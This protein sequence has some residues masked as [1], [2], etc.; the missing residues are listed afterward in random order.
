M[1][2]SLDSFQKARP[3]WGSISEYVTTRRYR[4]LFTVIVLIFALKSALLIMLHSP[5]VIAC[6]NSAVK[7][8]PK[9]SS[10]EPSRVSTNDARTSDGVSAQVVVNGNYNIEQQHNDIGHLKDAPAVDRDLIGITV[11]I[12]Y[13]LNVPSNWYDSFETTSP[14]YDETMISLHG[15]NIW[16]DEEGDEL[17]ELSLSSLLDQLQLTN[18]SF[19]LIGSPLDFPTLKK[20]LEEIKPKIFL[21]V[22]VFQGMTSTWVAHYFQSQ[23]SFKDSYVI[24]MDTW[25]LDIRFTWNGVKSKHVK[26]TKTLPYFIG[27]SRPQGGYST[28]YYHFLANCIKSGTTDRIV[29]LPTSSQNGAMTLLSHGI[30]PEF[31]YIDASHSNPD[32]MIDYENFFTILKPGGVIAFDDIGIESVKV[33]FH[34]LVRKYNLEYH[35]LHK[36]AYIYKRKEKYE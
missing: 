13:N 25:L 5:S 27:T 18:N 26:E 30:R 20:L 10:S 33:A 21:E 8:E 23:S 17:K 28:M 29:P 22:G 16:K 9:K 12:N 31:I 24:S 14:S 3:I 35:A 34:A 11:D 36:Q 6:E 19:K 15:H 2:T 32:V 7:V 1:H 4:C